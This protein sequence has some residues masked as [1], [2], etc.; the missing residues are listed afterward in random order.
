MVK[1][2]GEH[3]TLYISD[4]LKGKIALPNYWQYKTGYLLAGQGLNRDDIINEDNDDVNCAD[5]AAPSGE[6]S[7]HCDGNDNY[8]CEGEV[9]T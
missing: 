8:E 7:C 3:F 4:D 9:D 2:T 6:M 5:P 1:W